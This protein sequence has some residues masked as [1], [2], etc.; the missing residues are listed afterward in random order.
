MN[1]GTSISGALQRAGLLLKRDAP[2]DALRL[3]VLLTDGRVDAH[4]VRWPAAR[5]TLRGWC[6]SM[7]L[8]AGRGAA[9]CDPP[10]GLR[11]C[12]CLLAW[13][14]PGRPLRRVRWRSG[15][16]M[17]RPTSSCGPWGWG[18]AWTRRSWWVA[19]PWGCGV[20]GVP[21]VAAAGAAAGAACACLLWLARHCTALMPP[22]PPP[23]PQV[24]IL[25]GACGGGCDGE[26]ACEP[27]AIAQERYTEL[28]VKDEAPW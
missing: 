1:G 17:S 25:E 26:A 4:Q 27:S 3:V 24:G 9:P 16:R 5:C 6:V 23:P 10:A 22:P 28:Y 13:A 15:W 11:P 8:P 20:G 2:A 18:G 12:C 7:P 14:L 19:G 21:I